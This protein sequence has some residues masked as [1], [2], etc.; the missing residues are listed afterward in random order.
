MHKMCHK[1]KLYCILLYWQ[2]YAARTIC[3]LSPCLKYFLRLIY[4]DRDQFA[5][6]TWRRDFKK[7]GIIAL[8]IPIEDLVSHER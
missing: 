4:A 5:S 2:I 7:L 6:I 8:E 1:L 3:F